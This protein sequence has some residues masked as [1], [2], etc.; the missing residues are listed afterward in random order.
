MR[1][2]SYIRRGEFQTGWVTHILMRVCRSLMVD[3]MAI[4]KEGEQMSTTAALVKLPCIIAVTA[5]IHTSWTVPGYASKTEK[6]SISGLRGM[7]L[8]A[9]FNTATASKVRRANQSARCSYLIKSR[10]ADTGHIRSYSGQL[11]VLRWPRSLQG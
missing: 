7:I 2:E 3:C 1:C 9:T 5:G 10:L 4:R 6:V 8:A 11:E